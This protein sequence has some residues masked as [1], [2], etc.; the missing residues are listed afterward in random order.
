MTKEASS[1]KIQNHYGRGGLADRIL[2]VL[3]ANGA[4]VDSLRQ[5]DLAP[6]D[7]FHIRGREATAEVAG[8]AAI[9]AGDAVLDV[10]CGI[11]GPS[12]FLAQTFGCHVTGIDLT[13]EFCQVAEMLAA[14]TGL[15]DKVTYRQGDALDLPYGDAAFDVVWTQHTAMNIADK[16]RLYAQMF[17]VLKPGGR[18]AIYD[19][20][21]G[22]GGAI[23]Y[24]V[25]WARDAS[26]SFVQTPDDL[27]GYLKDAGFE[28]SEWRD[29]SEQGIAWVEKVR[30][31]AQAQGNGAPPNALGLIFGD[32]WRPLA[33]NMA[34]NLIE[35][36][37][38][39]YQVIARKPG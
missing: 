33:A 28:I 35:R 2:G 10:G 8:L 3:R 4:D 36:R 9:G 13:V 25:P 11:G 34:R 39:T 19:V 18:L 17:R 23:H 15:S 26:T 32:D 29:V 21:A 20:L 12:R 30:A 14:R 24:P 1:S 37:I 22:P 38:V 16:P 5:D 31:A 7:E 27:R 6:I